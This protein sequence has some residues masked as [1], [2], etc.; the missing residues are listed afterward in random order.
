N[1]S[2]GG[3]FGT[4]FGGLFLVLVLVGGV[5]LYQTAQLNAATADLSDNRIPSVLVL[6]KL[7]DAVMRFR[8][9]QDAA[10]LASDPA[11]IANV[12]SSRSSAV[13]DVEASWRD[14]QP[15]MDPG[16]E[17]E[18]LGPAIDAAWKDY[19]GQDAR[20]GSLIRAGDKDAAARFQTGDLSPLFRKLRE[21]IDEDLRYNVAQAHVSSEA[22][23]SAIARTV[24]TICLGTALAALLAVGF[25]LSLKRNVTARVVRMATS[26]RQLAARDYGFTLPDAALSDEIGDMA[27]ALEECRTGLKQADEMATT[28]ASSRSAAVARAGSLEDLSRAFEA[29]VGQM[30]A[31]VSA[32]AAEMKTRARSMTDTSGN[33]IQQATSV[34]AAAEQASANVQTVASAAEELSTSIAEISRLVAQS[35]KI[36]GKAK[37]DAART[38]GVVH[39]LAEGAQ[40]IGE[41]VGLISSIAG[42]TNLL[43]LNATIEA[44]RAGDAGK[45]FAVVASEVKG[46]ATQT[47]K[48]TEDIARQITEIQSA[49][50][51]AVSAIQGIGAIIGEISSIASAIAAAVE[52]QGS[53]TQEIARNVQQAAAGTQEVTSNITG[54]S[55]GAKGTGATATDVL[56]AAGK[57]ALKADELR[58]EVGRYIAGV[59]AA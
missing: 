43:A 19:L 42:Q 50:K 8:E 52:E 26:V 22:I 59:K 48:A 36:A 7:E 54:V 37:D 21:A 40:K 9:A 33:T 39:A 30:V 38:D 57:L 27:R 23:E 1:L 12:A 47:A 15:L 31:D 24:W 53:A 17:R 16:Q 10:V 4:A 45:G 44:A 41:V 3:R 13:D 32:S 6:S 18:R 20:L 56:D 5:D 46:L 28:Q 2:I 51:E 35:A 14:Y 34:A 55:D 49:T 25:A 11:T 58:G 29:R